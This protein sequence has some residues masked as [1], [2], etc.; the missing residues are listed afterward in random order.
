MVSL[1]KF[2]ISGKEV[3]EV[4]VD[5]AF[6][7]YRAHAQ[8]V[9]DY[10]VAMRKNKRQWSANT[11]GR[12]EISHSNKK[13][14]RQKGTGAARQGTLAAPQFRGGGIVFG[15][16]PKKDMFTRINKKER[17][18]SIHHLLAEK[19]GESRVVVLADSE[20]KE[21]KAKLMGEFLK[22]RELIGKRVL[23]VYEGAYEIEGHV[24]VKSDK[25][26]AFKR[27]LANF[28]RVGVTLA[29]N[30]NGY[31]VACAHDIVMTES[32]LTE[33]QEWLNTERKRT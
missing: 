6:V 33:V 1:K 25:H 12:S 9:K 7:S 13:P 26:V 5:E 29:K 27:S 23:F 8:M 22:K 3:G 17:R 31:D 19:M 24:S 4:T 2:D 14:H 10:L 21:A 30:L 32:A 20:M 11:K 15:P 16:K 28:P 18:S